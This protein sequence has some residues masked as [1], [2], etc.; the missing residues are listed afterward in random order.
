MFFL[1]V[2]K[3]FIIF[4]YFLGGS[5]NWLHT[6]G[7]EIPSSKLLTFLSVIYFRA[8]MMQ[9]D[10]LLRNMWLMWPLLSLP[11]HLIILSFFPGDSKK[12]FNSYWH[13]IPINQTS[14]FHICSAFSILFQICIWG[15]PWCRLVWMKLDKD[16]LNV[17]PPPPPC[18]Q[19]PPSYLVW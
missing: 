2:E 12:W 13:G 3:H 16:L 18:C 15:R 5:N 7:F 14:Y 10:S 11:K 19:P 1:Q 4:P 6:A 8:A 17:T 9:A